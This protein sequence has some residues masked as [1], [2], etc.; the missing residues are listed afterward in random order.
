MLEGGVLFRGAALP[1]AFRS[2]SQDYRLP[3][4]G[5]ALL[6][7]FAGASGVNAI[8]AKLRRCAI[9]TRKSSEEGLGQDFN[10]LHAQCEA[11]EALSKASRA[12]AGG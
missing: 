4:V 3:L 5:A 12:R 11:C 10:P 9:Y 2:S 7:P 8:T 1:L 6:W